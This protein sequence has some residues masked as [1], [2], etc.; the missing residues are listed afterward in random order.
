M[1]IN[2]DSSINQLMHKLG[3]YQSLINHVD[4]KFNKQRYQMK[5]N[6]YS[7]KIRMIGGQYGDAIEDNTIDIENVSILSDSNQ[8]KI[9][10][11]GLSTEVKKILDKINQDKSSMME[12]SSQLYKFTQPIDI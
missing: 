1:N 3:K 9:N 11:V 7:N 10:R 12:P 4:N 2:R 8:D 5:I 6:E